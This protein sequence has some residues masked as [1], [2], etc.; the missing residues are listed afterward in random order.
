MSGIGLR[1]DAVSLDD[2]HVLVVVIGGLIAQV[3]A[4]HDDD[5]IARTGR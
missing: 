1:N 5:A 4:A 3:V 2:R